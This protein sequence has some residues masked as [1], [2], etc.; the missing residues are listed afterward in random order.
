M[1]VQTI[2][3]TKVQDFEY[4]FSKFFREWYPRISQKRPGAWTQ[5]PISACFTS[6]P[7]VPVLRNDHCWPVKESS[8]LRAVQ[9]VKWFVHE[10]SDNHDYNSQPGICIAGTAADWRAGRGTD[11]RKGTLTADAGQLHRDSQLPL[12]AVH[13]SP[14]VS[15]HN[16]RCSESDKNNQCIISHCRHMLHSTDAQQFQWPKFQCRRTAC[17]EQLATAPMTKRELCTFPA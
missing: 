8:S 3:C 13:H 2:K 9:S 10:S 17:V 6:V 4:I 14:A 7:I 12:L 5:T 16:I 11:V 1:A 15:W